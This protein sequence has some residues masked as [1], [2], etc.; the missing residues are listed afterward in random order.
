MKQKLN[1]VDRIMRFIT[2]T[3]PMFM[4]WILMEKSGLNIIY[5]MAAL[6]VA[7][8][9]SVLLTN[10]YIVTRLTDIQILMGDKK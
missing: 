10:I 7:T 1:R 9:L 8:M 5:I 6:G 4:L 3:L 2:I